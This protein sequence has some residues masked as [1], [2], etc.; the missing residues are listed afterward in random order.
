MMLAETGAAAL[1]EA[2]QRSESTAAMNDAEL[3]TYWLDVV[4]WLK[5]LH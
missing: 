4:D 3:R 5:K 1:R 2:E